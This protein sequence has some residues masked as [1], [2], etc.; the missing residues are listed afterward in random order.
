MMTLH[1]TRRTALVGTLVA[2]ACLAI[3]AAAAAE[4]ISDVFDRVNRSV[5]VI[6]AVEIDVPGE[7]GE[8]P[9][10][11][12]VG[13]GVLISLD[14][15][16]LTAAHLVHAA[17]EIRVEFWGGQRVSARVV[18]SAPGADISLLQAETIPQD[19]VAVPLADSDR[20]RIGDEV[21]VIGA[22]YGVSHSLTVGHL[23]G[24]QRP[25]QTTASLGHAEFLQTDA[26]IN[27][28]NSGGPMFNMAGE[29]LG[30]V[31]HIISTSGGF[32][33]LGFA[34]AANVARELVIERGAPWHGIDGLFLSEDLIK[35]LNLPGP[36]VLVQRVV[37]DS[38]GAR[39]GLRGGFVKATIGDRTV[40]LGGDVILKAQGVPIGEAH[41][42][43]D[44]LRRV[45]PG[46][47]LAVTIMREGRIQELSTVLR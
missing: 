47:T 20:A 2:L 42:L 30:I 36:G 1:L 9:R 11:S 41:R 27:K 39:L 21:F 28:G 23:S 46:D 24:R 33:G 18:S 5:V 37:P 44:Q 3:A 45:D 43:R 10:V 29:V 34:V 8:S 38:T 16:I 19:A 12:S 14:G 7:E 35:I 4:T 15:K 17:S 26:A 40:I 13:S 25:G 6:R 32:E 31:S 22:P